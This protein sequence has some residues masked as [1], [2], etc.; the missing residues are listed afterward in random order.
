[1]PHVTVDNIRFF[2]DEAGAGTPVVFL[3]GFTLDH[4][5]WQPQVEFF[6]DRF[7]VIC[8]DARGHG[9]SDVTLTG[10]SR[11]HRVQ[12]LAGLVDKLNIDRFHLVGLSMGGSTAIGFALEQPERLRTLTVVSSGAAGYG[13]GRKIGRLDQIAKEQSVEAALEKWRAWSLAWYKEDRAELK[14]FLDKIMSGYTGA[15][16]RDPLRGQ[17][18]RED[19][20]SRVHRIK[21]PTA[22]FA[23]KLDKVFEELAAKLHDRISGSRLL[24]YPGT[25]HMLNLEQ[26]DRFNHDL[27][28]FLGENSQP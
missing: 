16:W 19:D 14:M 10:Y 2:Y 7:R 6:A 27:A 20:L 23:G 13:V 25:G 11:A 24:I 12:D 3:H 28:S 8:P 21:V 22:I 4:R 18:P 17:Y 9:K 5:M 1:M 15:T 26:P